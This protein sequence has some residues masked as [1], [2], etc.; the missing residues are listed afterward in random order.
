MYTPGL[1][2]SLTPASTRG[3]GIYLPSKLPNLPASDFIQ[4]KLILK[5]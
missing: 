2:S 4:P 1:S 3:R 5:F